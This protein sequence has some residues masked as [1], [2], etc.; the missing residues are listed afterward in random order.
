MNRISQIAGR[1]AGMSPDEKEDWNNTVVLMAAR[2][3][4]MAMELDDAD[5]SDIGAVE[6]W[7]KHVREEKINLDN[8]ATSH[9]ADLLLEEMGK[10]LNDAESER[11]RFE[12]EMLRNKKRCREIGMKAKALAV[13]FKGLAQ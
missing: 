11:R 13:K 4:D 12:D 9:K 3:D 2:L 7:S 10:I 8:M 1:I 5:L 6:K